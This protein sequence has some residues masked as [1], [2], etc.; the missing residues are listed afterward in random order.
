MT[1]HVDLGARL[2]IG[3]RTSDVRCAVRGCHRHAAVYLSSERVH[4]SGQ[5]L[6]SG[7]P[8]CAG[9]YP[10]LDHRAVA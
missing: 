9:C 8:V 5:V 4:A 3:R 7:A 10:E 6:P 2:P 1:D